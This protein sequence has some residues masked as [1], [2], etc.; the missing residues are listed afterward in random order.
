[1]A[2]LPELKGPTTSKS[3]A[4]L[5]KENNAPELLPSETTWIRT[6]ISGTKFCQQFPYQ[7]I[8]VEADDSG[9][10]APKRGL[11]WTFTLPIPPQ[12]LSINVPFAI[13]TYPTLGGIIEEHNGAPIRFIHFTGTTGVIFGR[14][15]SPTPNTLSPLESI[16]GG[17]IQAGLN[18]LTTASSLLNG[19]SY[20]VNAY[21][22]QAFDDAGSMTKMSGYYQFR[23]LQQFFDAYAELKKTRQGRKCRLAF[24]MWKDEA[25]YLC[26]PMSF[27]LNR[28]IDSPLEYRYDIQLK[29]TKRIRL[30]ETVVSL[31]TDVKA[32]TKQPS[33]LA[34]VLNTIEDARLVLQGAR[35]TLLAVRGDVDHVLFEPIR[36]TALFCKDALAVPI[37]LADMADSIIKDAQRTVILSISTVQDIKNF[38]QNFNNKF[39]Q[40]DKNLDSLLDSLS[41]LRSEISGNTELANANLINKQ[42]SHPAN[43]PFSDP[44]ANFKFFSAIN[45]GQ[46]KPSPVLATKIAR[47]TDRVSRLTRLDF[48]KKRDAIAKL[49]AEFANSIGIGDDTY[50]NIYHIN[51]PT[52]FNIDN[53]TNDDLNVLF[54]LNEVIIQLS[55]LAATENSNTSNSIIDSISQVAGAAERIGQAFTIPKSKFAVP[56]IYGYT[57][58]LLAQR[59]LGNP[60]RWMEIAALNGLQA[61]WVD[62][63]GF[64][65]DFLS[66]GYENKFAVNTNFHLFPNQ[67]IWLSSSTVYNELR[68][69]TEIK[70]ISDDY[71]IISVDGQADLDKFKL[72]EYAKLHAYLPNTVNSSQT[73]FIPSSE[74]TD[75]S[76]LKFR[77]IPGLDYNTELLATCGVDLLLDQKGDIVITEDG[78]TRYSAGITNAIQKLQLA[79]SIRKGKLNRHPNYG[80]PM[81]VGESIAD[82]DKNDVIRSL[83]TMIYSDPTYSAINSLGIEIAGPS[84]T[85]NLGVV[86]AGN[87]KNIPVSFN[88]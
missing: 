39:G 54:S 35:Q 70:K 85:I 84:G 36:E 68:H 17:T 72:N 24:A 52:V 15:P 22:I 40:V 65:L 8:V 19:K 77:D 4:E 38:K 34:T 31:P 21:D 3:L 20:V 18:T 28:G 73:I 58:E 88:F 87:N 37:G 47:E 32:V 46:L 44:K 81:E 53:I 45:I 66:N 11:G 67:S 41:E 56:F 30:N 25:V 33:V 10:Y 51:T 74:E 57:L 6:A 49:A 79:F 80:L 9:N 16:F 60:D 27:T 83:Q 82:I 61:P 26:Q 7:L 1:M 64:Y 48:Q 63:V 78:R 69:I 76:D 13:Q 23:L 59:Y 75:G 42:N 29:A 2:L 62:E 71:Y 86:L 14:G 55:G 50:N 5:A 43:N 12:S